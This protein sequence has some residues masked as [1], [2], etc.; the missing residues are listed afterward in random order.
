MFLVKDFKEKEIIFLKECC[1]QKE[2]MTN[3]PVPNP[4]LLDSFFKDKLRSS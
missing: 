3:K 4:N 2:M 1:L